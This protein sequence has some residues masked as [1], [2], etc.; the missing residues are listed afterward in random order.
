MSE[1]Y[2]VGETTAP[3]EWRSWNRGRKPKPFPHLS[4]IVRALLVRRPTVIALV[5]G[6]AIS[7][8]VVARA[9]EHGFDLS[10][11]VLPGTLFTHNAGLPRG[12]HNIPG[13][14][15]DGQ[16]VYRLALDPFSTRRTAFGI[17]LDRPAYR[18]QRILLPLL[19]W[20]IHRAFLLPP[21]LVLILINCLAIV[22]IAYVCAL[23]C[24]SLGLPLVGAL[25][26][27]FAPGLIV[28]AQ[29]DLNE[30]LAW[31]LTISG[32][33]VWHKRRFPQAAALLVLAVLARETTA[34][35][36]LGIFS[37][38]CF[39]YVRCPGKRPRPANLL[40]LVPVG[41]LILWDLWLYRVW[42]QFPTNPSTGGI[43]FPFQ[44]L[45]SLV[46]NPL[47]API[48]RPI[49]ISWDVEHFFVLGLLVA[50]AAY[51]WRSAG[52][53]SIRWSWGWAALLALT[54]RG[55]S[56]DAGF[57]RAVLEAY[58][59]GLLILLAGTGR[60]SR[61]MLFGSALLSSWI[62]TWYIPHL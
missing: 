49:W 21:T 30:P 58:M 47:Q 54:L 8:L 32:I 51:V 60:L 12:V 38:Y 56:N 26:V 34:L 44:P 62:A 29:R 25:L 11:F 17:T 19:A 55:W 2:A 40:S 27:A 46:G 13:T 52:T 42:H 36:P 45:T 59:L 28:A 14:G 50:T 15:Y 23:Y 9:A 48:P 39:R 33:Y 43:A 6:V 18:Q 37:D 35:I 3:P 10:V 20:V 31:A 1:E 61:Y 4:A 16:F 41:V 5:A 22:C 7:S 24:R 53:S 57:L